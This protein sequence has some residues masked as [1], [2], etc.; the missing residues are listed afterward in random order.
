MNDYAEKRKKERPVKH[1]IKPIPAPAE[2]IPPK[3]SSKDKK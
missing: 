1:E 2:K 3:L